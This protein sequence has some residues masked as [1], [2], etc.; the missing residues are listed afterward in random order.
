MTRK[1]FI[2]KVENLFANGEVTK[3]YEIFDKGYIKKYNIIRQYAIVA[4]MDEFD[5]LKALRD[6]ENKC[7]YVVYVI[8]GEVNV[9]KY[10][11]EYEKALDYVK[12]L[13]F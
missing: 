1:Q 2:T 4:N 5:I 8:C 12:Y 13:M 3:Y 6:E 11:M 9:T 10:P 7:Y